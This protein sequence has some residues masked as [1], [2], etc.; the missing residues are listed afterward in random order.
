MIGKRLRERIDRVEGA[1]DLE[2][3]QGFAAAGGELRM[4]EEYSRRV[5][6]WVEV[7]RAPVPVRQ[8]APFA[9]GIL[10]GL[11]AYK[12]QIWVLVPLALIAA[13]KRSE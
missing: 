13:R 12:P 5:A 10:L 2:G 6:L 8:R 4:V 1:R 3:R 9:A 11:L 7:P